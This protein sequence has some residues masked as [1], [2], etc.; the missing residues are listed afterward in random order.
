MNLRSRP[1]LGWL[2]CILA[3]T[4]AGT[5][6]AQTTGDIRGTLT[7]STGAVLPGA[8]VTI[9]GDVLLGGSRSMVTNELGVYR[10]I[11]VPIGTYVVEVGLRSRPSA[12]KDAI[13]PTAG[14]GRHPARATTVAETVTVTGESPVV[15]VTESGVSSKLRASSSRTSPPNAP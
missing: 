9:Y 15:D 5:A 6:Q 14:D 3:L 12:T 13:T 7:D 1:F 4:L 10:F 2:V 11:S 8:S